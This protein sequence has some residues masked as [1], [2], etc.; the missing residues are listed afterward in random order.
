MGHMKLCVASGRNSNLH[1]ETT[2]KC[3]I[4]A[5]NLRMGPKYL[6]VRGAEELCR[7][8]WVLTPTLSLWV[9][10][11]CFAFFFLQLSFMLQ[12]NFFLLHELKTLA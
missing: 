10:C 7:G 8:V 6:Q 12:W 2:A 11:T 4:Q 9:S 1:E 3:T 5:R